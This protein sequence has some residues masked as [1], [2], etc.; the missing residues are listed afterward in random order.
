MRGP[1]VV[2]FGGRVNTHTSGA[3]FFRVVHY[4]PDPYTGGRVP[5]GALLHHDSKVTFMV[6]PREPCKICLGEA[7]AVVVGLAIRDLLKATKM[8]VPGSC[9][10]QV[11]AADGVDVPSGVVD[12]FAWVVKLLAGKK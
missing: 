3:C 12:P 9:G 1:G 7:G 6:S 11:V 8:D 10:P 4:I 2:L 5:F